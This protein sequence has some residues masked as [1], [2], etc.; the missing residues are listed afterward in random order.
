MRLYLDDDIAS[1]VL[2]RALRQA[3]HDVQIPADAGLSGS[4]DPAHLTHAIREG[5]V[6]MT[7]NHEDFEELHLL[8]RQAQGAH[9]GIFAVRRDND[10]RRN[11]NPWDIVRALRNLEN[12]GV[13]SANEYTILNHWQ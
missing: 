4:S 11:M 13:P 5:R 6:T 2:V 9:P 3:G 10:P 1:A 12:A 7:R 8:I